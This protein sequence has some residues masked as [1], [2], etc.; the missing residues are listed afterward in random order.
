MIYFAYGSNMDLN[1]LRERQIS[2]EF[3]GKALLP[4]YIVKFNKIA[5]KKTG[6]GYANIVYSSGV[7]VEGI[8]YRIDNIEVLDNYEGYP[9]HYEKRSIEVLLN[10]APIEAVVYVALDEKINNNLKP[11]RAYLNRLLNAK[12]HLSEHYFNKLKNTQTID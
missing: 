3:L 10:N 7:F 4:N 5:S 6:I 8:L 1:R 12:E 11:E 9:N 2:F